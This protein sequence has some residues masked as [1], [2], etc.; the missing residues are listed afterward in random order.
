MAPG[1]NGPRGAPVSID[2]LGFAR[3]S[4]L[5]QSTNGLCEKP[6]RPQILRVDHHLSLGGF[7]LIAILVDFRGLPKAQWQRNWMVREF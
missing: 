5:P 2:A 3:V 4:G 7:C 1:G 6:C